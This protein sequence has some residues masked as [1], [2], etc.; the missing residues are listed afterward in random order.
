MPKGLPLLNIENNDEPVIVNRPGLRDVTGIKSVNSGST[1]SIVSPGSPSS[2]VSSPGSTISTASSTIRMINSTAPSVPSFSVMANGKKEKKVRSDFTFEDGT[3]FKSLIDTKAFGTEIGEGSYARVYTFT[4]GTKS[5]ILK[6]FPKG[7]ISEDV[8]NEIDALI[9]LRDS[10]YVVKLLAAE[11]YN[12]KAYILY[13]YVEGL[14]FDE[15]VRNKPSTEEKTHVE[16]ELRKGL[17]NIHE[18]GY[19]HRDIKPDNIWVPADTSIP[20][21]Y[22]DLG[23]AVTIGKE[24]LSR[25]ASEY[26]A[27]GNVG[28]RE[29][30]PN[31]NIFALN[32]VFREIK[33]GSRKRRSTKKRTRTRRNKIRKHKTTRRN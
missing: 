14:R 24:T 19:V 15:W 3:T 7:I 2:T 8:E 18:K 6:T 22:L 10:P 25:G 26:K 16:K 17:D 27:E 5:Y 20:P 13:P 9:A 28:V 1:L 23:L 33:G 21:F 4:K 29:Q 11:V 12:T 32:K 31:I 30:K